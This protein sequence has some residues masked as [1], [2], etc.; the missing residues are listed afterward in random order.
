MQHAPV[1]RGGEP[2][3]KLLRD[4]VGLGLREPPDAPQQCGKVLAVHVLHGEERPPL[5]LPDVVHA[6]NV[7]M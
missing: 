1:V 6:A 3:A 2:G 7:G 5:G 4:L